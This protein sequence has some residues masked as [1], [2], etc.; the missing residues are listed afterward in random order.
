MVKMNYSI[1]IISITKILHC[2]ILIYQFLLLIST[3]W[4]FQHLI[5][6]FRLIYFLFILLMNLNV[7]KD[8]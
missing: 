5:H 2:N 6:H 4:L 7:K 1:C 8:F 3:H